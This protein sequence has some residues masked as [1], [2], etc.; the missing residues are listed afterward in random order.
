MSTIREQTKHYIHYILTG[1]IVLVACSAVLVRNTVVAHAPTPAEPQENA[2]PVIEEVRVVEKV[3]EPIKK[4][5]QDIPEFVKGIYVSGWVAGTTTSMN[6]IFTLLDTTTANT[7]IIDIKDATGRLSYQPRDPELQKIG[8]GTNRIRNLDELLTKLHEKNIYVIGRVAVFQDPYFAT[9]HPDSAFKDTRSGAL[10]NDNKGLAWLKTNDVATWD[11]TVRIAR[12]A[13]AQGFDEINLD[14]VR[15]PSDGPL[16]YLDKSS[17]TSSR[18]DIVRDFFIYM[19]QKIRQESA[20]PLSADIFGLATSATGDLGIGQILE[21]IAPYVDYVA[22]MV[23]P[24][25]FAGGTYGIADPAEQPYAVIYKSMSDAIKKMTVIQENP[26][27]LRPWLQD[28]DLGAVYTVDMVKAQI[29]AV[30]DVGL[31]SWMMW[32]PRTVYTKGAF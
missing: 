24:S 19:D 15:F 27:K 20:I 31:D 1:I 13:Y 23:Y 21:Y 25:H 9:V 8:V 4:T 18:T 3:V 32:D 26:Q 10:W 12:D 29:Q 6:R 16:S 2:A 11:Y 28:F 7:V 5:H 14:Y 22:P 17:I 30:Q